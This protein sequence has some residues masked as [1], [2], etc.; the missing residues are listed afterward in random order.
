MILATRKSPE[1]IHEM[2]FVILDGEDP[3]L[4][5]KRMGRLTIVCGEEEEQLGKVVPDYQDGR[6]TILTKNGRSDKIKTYDFSG[7]SEDVSATTYTDPDYF[8]ISF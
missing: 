6:L 5:I 2:P 8:R 7:K 1:L 4:A 3:K